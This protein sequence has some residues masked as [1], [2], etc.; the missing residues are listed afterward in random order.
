MDLDSDRFTLCSNEFNLEYRPVPGYPHLQAKYIRNMDSA[1]IGFYISIDQSEVRPMY[2]TGKV[3][4][5]FK[6]MAIEQYPDINFAYKRAIQFTQMLFLMYNRHIYGEEKQNPI[7][8]KLFTDH[9]I[10]EVYETVEM[11]EE[12]GSGQSYG[13]YYSGAKNTLNPFNFGNGVDGQIIVVWCTA[14]Q[15]VFGKHIPSKTP[16]IFIWIDGYWVSYFEISLYPH[17]PGI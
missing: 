6:N 8:M 2:C 12:I 5:Y 14:E 17:V 10:F 3:F 1:L 16:M 4:K 9:T 7:F 13:Y 11:N 15:H